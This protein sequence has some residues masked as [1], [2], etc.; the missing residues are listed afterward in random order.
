MPD[1]NDPW[2]VSSDVSQPKFT[3]CQA[4]TIEPLASCKELVILL[5]VSLLKVV[6]PQLP[7]CLQLV[8]CSDFKEANDFIPLQNPI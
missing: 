5:F 6:S 3:Q 7:H 1:S 8:E 4:L 2:A